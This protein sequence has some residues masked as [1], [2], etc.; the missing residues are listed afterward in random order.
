VFT[1]Y[2]YLWHSREKLRFS[3]SF[4]EYIDLPYE[5]NLHTPI[6]AKYYIPIM[7]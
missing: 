7:V 4:C 3:G 2:F 5:L 1:R 6:T